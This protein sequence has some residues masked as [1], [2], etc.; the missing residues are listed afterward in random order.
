MDLLLTMAIILSAVNENRWYHPTVSTTWQWQLN[1][2]PNRSYPNTNYDVDL[3]DLDLFD[4]EQS[5]IDALHAE[6]K[7]VVCYFSAGSF[8]EWRDDADSFP[9]EAL[10]NNYDG[11][12]GERWLDIRHSGLRTII[13]ERLDLAQSKQCDGV[14]PDNMD[15]YTNDTGFALTAEDQL[16]YNMFLSESAHERGL[17][18]GLKNDLSQVEALVKYFDFHVNEQCHLFEECDLLTP[19]INAGKPVF[20]AEY[21]E[22]YYSEDDFIVLCQDAEQRQFQTLYLPTAL[23]DTFRF[24]CENP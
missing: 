15:A 7:R 18:I 1:T 24:S 20:N 16:S 4:T 13:L 2:T 22:R 14:E 23:D 11:W 12:E 9:E 17:A 8:E 21:D 6:D 5:T 3:Y 10:G 19:F